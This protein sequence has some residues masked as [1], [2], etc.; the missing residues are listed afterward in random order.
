VVGLEILAS[1]LGVASVWLL[2]RQNLWCWPTGIA[3]VSLYV[4]IF[5]D[6]QLYSQMGLQ[7]IYVVLQIYGWV[8]W[9]RGGGEA[10]LPVGRI[11]L[12]EGAGW[13]AAIGLGTAALGH[14]MERFTDA[15]LAYW[16]AAV[17]AMSLTASYLQARKV[18]ECWLLWIAV[19]V[20][21]IGIYAAQ[22]LYPTLGLYA[23]LLVLSVEGYRAW[24]R[25]LPPP[26]RSVRLR[27]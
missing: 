19:D 22:G 2:G 17:T 18:L 25:T 20:V 13:L 6:A 4:L 15:E 21:A 14:A 23:V 7:G 8:H 11:G 10:P 3:M 27:A 16:D 9:V 5:H 1:V 24:G 26:A 12:R